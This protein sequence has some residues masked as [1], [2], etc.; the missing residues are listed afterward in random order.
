MNTMQGCLGKS[1][2]WKGSGT[3]ND[4][5][6]LE[7][8]EHLIYFSKKVGRGTDFAGKY[9]KLADDITLT[10]LW[11]S[12]GN[13]DQWFEGTF[14]GGGNTVSMVKLSGKY[15][16]NGFFGKVGGQAVISGLY[17]EGVMAALPADNTLG[18]LTGSNYGTIRNCSCTVTSADI[19]AGGSGKK[20][21][22]GMIAGINQKGGL[23]EN[24]TAKGVFR[25]APAK[26]A[27][28]S[29]ALLYIGGL[30]GVNYG[31][32]SGQDGI[33]NCTIDMTGDFTSV[34]RSRLILGG[35]MAEN[36]VNA[37]ADGCTLSGSL[38]C[39]DEIYGLSQIN[40]GSITG[41]TSTISLSVSRAGAVTLKLWGGTGTGTGTTDRNHM[42]G[43]GKIIF[44]GGSPED[45]QAIIKDIGS[46]RL[47][48]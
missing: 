10:G 31:G 5:Y 1:Y 13:D 19:S 6:L 21:Y 2:P 41:C 26:P 30:A 40:N 32:G 33:L 43:A 12:I 34:T 18:L 28:G 45:A 39:A 38:T 37:M 42:M 16:D 20:L 14:D 11:P 24:C 25:Y 29:E 8:E 4:P 3:E 47:E 7:S 27:S 46:F 35:L 15:I 17:L 48:S 22:A 23:I 44:T 36:G 9:L